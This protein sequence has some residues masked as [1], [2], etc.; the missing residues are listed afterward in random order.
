MASSVEP[1]NSEFVEPTEFDFAA[2]SLL[3]PACACLSSKRWA[4]ASWI[5]AAA[6]M[7]CHA[8]KLNKFSYCPTMD[9]ARPRLT[10]HL[11]SGWSNRSQ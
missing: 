4:D 8:G 1:S 3:L 10:H 9:E 5:S 6:V 2:A 11:R 7:S